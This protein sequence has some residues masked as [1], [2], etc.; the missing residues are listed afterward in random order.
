MF[1]ESERDRDRYLRSCW[2]TSICKTATD[3]RKHPMS[4]SH[5]NV[6]KMKLIFSC[7]PP[8]LPLRLRHDV[9]WTYKQLTSSH[10]IQK[11]T[12]KHNENKY[13]INHLHE[14][15]NNNSVAALLSPQ[16]FTYKYKFPCCVCSLNLVDIKTHFIQLRLIWCNINIVSSSKHNC[17]SRLQFNWNLHMTFTKKNVCVSLASINSSSSFGWERQRAGNEISSKRRA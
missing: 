8:S 6:S 12:W 15:P 11:I 13:R 2:K 7:P 17:I 5:C 9:G 4:D 16:L 3:S 14:T 10:V 1:C